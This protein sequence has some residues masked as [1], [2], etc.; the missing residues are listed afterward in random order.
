MNIWNIIKEWWYDTRDRNEYVNSFNRDFKNGYRMG[1][2]PIL[3]K[4][5]ICSGH[6][7]YASNFSSRFLG[8]SRGG[9]KIDTISSSTFFINKHMASILALVILSNNRMCRDLLSLGFDTLW[10]GQFSWKLQSYI[11]PSP[12]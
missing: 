2:F 12:Q 5:S 4:V 3:L 1:Y 9:L 10:V 11:L 7:D 6:P 8:F